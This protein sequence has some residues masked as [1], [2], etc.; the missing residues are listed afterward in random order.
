MISNFLI[1]PQFTNQQQGQNYIDVYAPYI[2][3]VTKDGKL[4]KF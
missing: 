4:T 1:G 3:L 2:W